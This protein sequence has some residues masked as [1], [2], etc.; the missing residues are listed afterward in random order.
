MTE[1]QM[2]NDLFN[3]LRALTES[4][5]RRLR[6][7]AIYILGIVYLAHKHEAHN[8]LF[9]LVQTLRERVRGSETW[10]WPEFID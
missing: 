3:E 6:R 2:V 4:T 7:R 1:E 5:D 8:E 10:D 9:E